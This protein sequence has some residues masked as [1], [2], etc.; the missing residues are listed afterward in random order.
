MGGH[1]S[2]QVRVRGK[3]YMYTRPYVAV[4]V[5]FMRVQGYGVT[6]LAETHMAGYRAKKGHFRAR[7]QLTRKP[8]MGVL[9]AEIAVS[10][11]FHARNHTH[12]L[13]VHGGTSVLKTTVSTTIVSC[14]CL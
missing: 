7:K 11:Q 4:R 14:L 12:F 3:W 5:Y 1:T 13:L 10:A 8:K 2:P 6:T 9:R